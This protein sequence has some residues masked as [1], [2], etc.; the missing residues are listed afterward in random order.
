M[1]RKRTAPPQVDKK[2]LALFAVGLALAFG[3]LAIGGG[4]V[5]WRFVQKNRAAPVDLEAE[6]ESD[7]IDAA[8]AFAN[9]SSVSPSEKIEFGR[10]FDR[11]RTVM[12]T[13]TDI[14]E[15]FDVDRMNFELSR[16]NGQR[17]AELHAVE[18][19]VIWDRVGWSVIMNELVTFE[20]YE[21]RHVRWSEDRQEAAVIAVLSGAEGKGVKRRFWLRKDKFEWKLFDVEDLDHAFRAVHVSAAFRGPD[22]GDDS[23]RIQ[24]AV[25]GIRGA[26][27]LLGAKSRNL[28]D[29][30]AQLLPSRGVRLPNPLAAQREWVEGVLKSERGDTEGSLK[31]FELAAALHPSM[32]ILKLWR[33]HAMMNAKRFD[34]AL[35]FIRGYLRDLGPDALVFGFEGQILEALQ[36]KPEALEAYRKA[37]DADA[38]DYD[39][40]HGLRRTLENKAELGERLFQSKKATE[41]FDYLIGSARTENDRAS[42]AVLIAAM[43]R[44]RPDDPRIAVEEIRDLVSLKKFDEAATRFREGLKAAEQ[45]DRT[46]ILNAYLFAMLSEKKAPEAYEAVPQEFRAAAF[47]SLAEELEDSSSEREF[48]DKSEAPAQTAAQLKQLLALHRKHEP[49]DNWLNLFEGALFQSSGEFDKAEAFFAEGMKK[50]R[51]KP[52]DDDADRT[53]RDAFRWRR[54]TCLYKLKQ[55]MKAYLAVGPDDATF[56]QLANAYDFDKDSAGLTALIARH[57]K[58]FPEALCLKYWR[59]ELRFL[60]AEYVAAAAGFRDYREVAGEKDPE[61]YRSNE[62]LLRSLVRANDLPAARRFVQEIGTDKASLGLRGAIEAAAGDVAA[63][64]LLLTEQMKQSGGLW[65]FYYDEDFVRLF[66]AVPFANLKTRFP[67]PS[68]KKDR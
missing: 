62:R 44:H 31:H 55:G 2:L 6:R 58:E 65:M 66:E 59:A 54:V 20:K 39:A 64:E 9:V 41:L 28:N 50:L 16:V 47:R 67:D 5:A 3:I 12:K 53:L 43:K 49:G 56:R 33:G 25:Q 37:L 38:D 21:L 68:S 13:G 32:P 17:S 63:L 48:L 29:V 8:E 30:E 23:T 51:A 15:L 52:Q 26:A 34:E 27:E 57:E 45:A 36:R 60:K 61:S 4:W 18:A 22:F 19:Q 46:R 14:D 10:I 24:Q 1:E 42:V 40:M 11:M 35:G 7:R